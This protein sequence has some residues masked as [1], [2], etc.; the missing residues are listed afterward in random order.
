MES[1]YAVKEFLKYAYNSWKKPKPLYVLIAG[2]ATYDYKDYLQGGKANTILYL[3]PNTRAYGETGSD[4]WFVCLDGEDDLLPDMFIGRIPARTYQEL[5]AAVT[6]IINYR[7]QKY[8]DFYKNVII[9]ADGQ[10]TP[11]NPKYFNI[12]AD[13]LAE[14]LPD[15][16]NVKK[17]YF[18]DSDYTTEDI[19]TEIE[20]GALLVVYV[21]HGTVDLWSDELILDTS[22]IGLLDNKDKLPFVTA[23]TCMDGYYFDSYEDWRCMA[24]TFLFQK[25][26]GSIAGFSATGM[27]I[28]PGHKLLGKKLFST[29]FSEDIYT[30]GE[31]TALAKLKLFSESGSIYEDLI[32]TYHLFS[33]PALALKREPKEEKSHSSSKVISSSKEEEDMLKGPLQEG[34]ERLLRGS[35][36][37][38][39]QAQE[40]RDETKTQQESKPF[41]EDITLL[42]HGKAQPSYYRKISTPAEGDLSELIKQETKKLAKVELTE[43]ETPKEPQSSLAQAQAISQRDTATSSLKE[44]RSSEQPKTILGKVADVFRK[45]VGNVKSFFQRISSAIKSFFS[46]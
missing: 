45:I 13:E 27:G 43:T 29:I 12:V 19:L 44:G 30:L 10:Y 1:P 9:I 14:S 36:A 35:I 3:I 28:P 39:D 15:Y 6:K 31:A 5:D 18:A 20:K 17:F 26:R 24:E 46:R 32:H 34:F 42:E 2:D 38:Y 21:G 23:F 33:D 16:L 11:N 37:N 41:P 22:T 8:Q 25:D 4:N 7:K 40:W